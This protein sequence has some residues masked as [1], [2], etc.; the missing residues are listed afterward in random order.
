MLLHPLFEFPD[1]FALRRQLDVRVGRMNFRA[2]GVAHQGHAD[3][4]QDARLHQPRVERVAEIVE[5]DVADSGILECRVPRALHDADRA[6]A[7]VDHE[8]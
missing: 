5:T 4:L 3:F 8:L 6:S 7:E 2:G 1:G